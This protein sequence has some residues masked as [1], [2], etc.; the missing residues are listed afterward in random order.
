MQQC[1]DVD[2]RVQIS[3]ALVELDHSSSFVLLVENHSSNPV[4][5]QDGDVL[6]TLEE[7]QPQD[8]MLSEG[9]SSPSE[10]DLDLTSGVAAITPF[11]AGEGEPPLSEQLH[12]DGDHLTKEE[13]EL[14]HSLIQEYQDVFSQ[15]PLDMGSTDLIA[16]AIN[17][18]SHPPIKK[19]ARRIPFVLRQKVEELTQKLL[20]SGPRYLPAA[21]GGGVGRSQQGALHGITRRR[22][23]RG[24]KLPGSP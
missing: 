18:E 4:K 21:N 22:P 10:Q 24:T 17:T 13:Q 3:E 2:R 16:H 15:G 20:E 19:A 11:A 12:I 14:V 23:G 8:G 7:L 6:G 9:T 5:L 1:K